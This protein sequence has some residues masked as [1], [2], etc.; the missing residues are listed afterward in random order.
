MKI[1][2]IHL[3]NQCE[4][5]ISTS[6]IKGILKICSADIFVLTK[7]LSIFK[8][9]KN[10]KQVYLFDDID[11]LLNKNFDILINLHPDFKDERINA[12]KKIGFNYSDDNIFDVLY[13]NG[14]TKS[15]IFQMYYRLCGLTW[16]GEGY[17]FNYYPKNRMKEE[18]T[19]VS[20]SN[21]KLRNFVVDKLKLEESRLWNIPFKFNIF[22]Q[23]D[24]INRCK[25]IITDDFYILNLATFLRKDI[26]FLQTINY[27]FKIE[28]FGCAKIYKV[29]DNI[30]QLL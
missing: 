5:F 19:G 2:I 20:V 12:Y 8:H 30:L 3:G 26:F 21:V 9:N 18:K 7:N 29:P 22:K 1:L 10:I 28:T 23:L 15:N 17:D 27:N 4:C 6:V 14:K 25:R 13:G 11:V 24:E 16:K